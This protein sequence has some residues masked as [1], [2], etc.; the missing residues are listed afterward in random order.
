MKVDVVFLED[1]A[2]KKKGE[3]FTCD[4]MIA[5][6]LINVAKVAEK[7]VIGEEKAPKKVAEKK[8]KTE[9]K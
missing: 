2:T 4:S 3:S 1:Y 9:S 6:H 5:S 7:K 8:V